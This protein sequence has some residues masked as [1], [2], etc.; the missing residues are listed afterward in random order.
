MLANV[1]AGS[2]ERHRGRIRRVTAIDEHRYC[3]RASARARSRSAA[4]RSAG[5]RRA[6]G[7][8]EPGAR[9]AGGLL[10]EDRWR[11]PEP[12]G[13]FRAGRRHHSHAR[14]PG[15]RRERLPRVGSRQG[16]LQPGVLC[17]AADRGVVSAQPAHGGPGHQDHQ[18]PR[19]GG[20][21]A[22]RPVHRGV[23]R[24]RPCVEGSGEAQHL[25]AAREAHSTAGIHH[26]QV[27]RPS[28]DAAGQSRGD[29]R[30][31][32]R[33]AWRRGVGGRRVVPASLGSAGRRPGA[34]EGGCDD[35]SAA[36]RS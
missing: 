3:A 27:P 18:G 6:T 8:V 25:L 1:A 22:V 31:L 35:L 28:A 11:A 15:H 36:R 24:H 2:L 19:P 5:G 12:S 16:A 13:W 4:A 20:D 7:V 30:R 33:G 26:R 10:R 34:A 9:D 23:H 17:R 21:V 29:G 14:D 32:L